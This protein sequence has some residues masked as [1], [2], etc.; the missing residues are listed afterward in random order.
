MIYRAQIGWR[1]NEPDEENGKTQVD[2]REGKF[3]Y[4][5]NVKIIF[6]I[7]IEQVYNQTMEF[8]K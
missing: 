8:I 5:Y 2:L 7:K 1:E 3:R 4:Q 6:F